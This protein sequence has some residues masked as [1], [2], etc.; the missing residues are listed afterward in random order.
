M[1]GKKNLHSSQ[2]IKVPNKKCK[3]IGL[4]IFYYF[5]FTIIIQ[6]NTYSTRLGIGTEAKCLLS[7]SPCINKNI[8]SR[9]PPH[10]K[11]VQNLVHFYGY[12]KGIPILY[13]IAKNIR[14][15]AN[16]IQNRYIYK[17]IDNIPFLCL[18]L[19]T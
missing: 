13:R 9:S 11:K 5:N 16:L 10:R 2:I 18:K 17:N 12:K 8:A 19:C 3:C 6:A 4:N 7:S 1:E 15:M 14:N